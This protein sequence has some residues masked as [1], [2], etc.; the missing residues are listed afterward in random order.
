VPSLRNGAHEPAVAEDAEMPADRV[1]MQA[2]PL[3]ELIRVEAVA[4]A[5]QRLDDHLPLPLSVH[6]LH[7]G[8]N[9]SLSDS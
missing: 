8:A 9:L 6:V 7:P 1:R 2:E 5:L 4:L 3:C